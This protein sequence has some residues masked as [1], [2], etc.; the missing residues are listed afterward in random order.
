VPYLTADGRCDICDEDVTFAAATSWLRDT[1]TCPLCASLPR[2]RALMA[3]LRSYTPDWTTRRIYEAA[4]VGRGLSE[5][6]ARD[7]REYV[8]S[9][10]VPGHPL[11]GVLPGGHRNEDL[12]HLGFES[13]SFDLVITQDV[14]EHVFDP[15]AAFAEIGRVLRPGGLHLFTTPLVNGTGPSVCRARRG[16]SGEVELLAPAVY[17]GNPVDPR[18]SLV[19]WDWGYDIVHVIYEASRMPTAIVVIDDLGRGIRAAYVE[20]LVSAKSVVPS[21][22]A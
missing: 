9:H 19:T 17:H 21:E 4:P 2:E 15:A 18:G 3:C 12:E 7:A 8:S 10:F 22:P 5:R 11:G 20:V 6:L 13:G 16:A 1:F 14:L